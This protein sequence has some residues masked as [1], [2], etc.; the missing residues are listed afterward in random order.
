MTLFT[1]QQVNVPLESMQ[2]DNVIKPV[3]RAPASEAGGGITL[4]SAHY[5]AG[6][7]TTAGTAHSLTLLL[8]NSTGA[9]AGTVSDTLGGTANPFSTNS[10]NAFTL[11]NTDLEAGQYLV[12]RKNETNTSTPVRSALIVE[13]VMGRR[14]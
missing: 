6:T 8:Y 10:F 4:V 12:V 13:Y 2:G 7:A 1:V 3:L 14:P 5:F 9:L 11:T